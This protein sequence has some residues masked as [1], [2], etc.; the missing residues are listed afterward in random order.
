MLT[1]NR[2]YITTV[3]SV[4]KQNLIFFLEAKIIFFIRNQINYQKEDSSDHLKHEKFMENKSKELLVRNKLLAEFQPFTFS[5]PFVV[6]REGTMILGKCRRRLSTCFTLKVSH[7][8]GEQRSQ[9]LRQ[10][11]KPRSSSRQT[12]LDV[13]FINQHPWIV[14]RSLQTL[15]CRGA[16]GRK[17]TFTITL[18][19]MGFKTYKTRDKIKSM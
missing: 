17:Q 16:K 8:S 1:L 7:S 19:M 9:N 11:L 3:S 4:V 18:S 10:Y 12:G 5:M 14:I 2:K 6:V 13:S 15:G